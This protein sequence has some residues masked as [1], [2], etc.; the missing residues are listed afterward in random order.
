MASLMKARHS[1]MQ[2]ARLIGRAK[3]SIRSG[4]LSPAD[5]SSRSLRCSNGKAC[6]TRMT[7][8]GAA[9]CPKRLRVSASASQKET[10]A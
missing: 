7:V 3:P 5:A 4:A 9:Y 1:I 8:Q 2:I 6:F 10:T